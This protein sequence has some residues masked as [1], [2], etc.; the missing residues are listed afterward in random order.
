MEIPIFLTLERTETGGLQV[1]SQ[2][3][4]RTYVPH[5]HLKRYTYT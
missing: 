4:L 5:T 1:R 2:E 3:I